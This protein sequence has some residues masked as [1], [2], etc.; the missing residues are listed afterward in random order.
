MRRRAV[1][2]ASRR[3]EGPGEGM[4][5]GK[6]PVYGVESRL[7]PASMPGANACL[8]EPA[9]DAHPGTR[10]ARVSRSRD[11]LQDCRP[12]GPRS[13]PPPIR[14]AVVGPPRSVASLAGPALFFAFGPHRGRRSSRLG[15]RTGL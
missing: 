14:T 12:S 15:V 4:R 5:A 2:K 1:G 6:R 7:E 9:A 13:D 11:R 3:D 8:S 10:A